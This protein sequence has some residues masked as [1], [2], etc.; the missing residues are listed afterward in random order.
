MSPSL[1]NELYLANIFLRQS[2][3][4]LS[5]VEKDHYIRNGKL[6]LVIP[7]EHTNRNFNFDP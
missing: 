7:W 5:L 2:K 4:K 3:K 1:D 6:S